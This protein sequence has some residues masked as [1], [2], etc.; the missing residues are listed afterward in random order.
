MPAL[1]SIRW[2]RAS[3]QSPTKLDLKMFASTRP[4]TSVG[5]NVNAMLDSWAASAFD[6]VNTELTLQ[7]CD[8]RQQHRNVVLP[9]VRRLRKLG[10]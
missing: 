3:F 8:F 1:E 7:G 2:F 9:S 4:I 10:H 5:E 6:K